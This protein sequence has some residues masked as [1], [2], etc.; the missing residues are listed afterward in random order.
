ML[1]GY[2]FK[3][4]NEK[5]NDLIIILLAALC[6]FN[7]YLSLFILL[8]G[9]KRLEKLAVIGFIFSLFLFHI[10]LYFIA[11]IEDKIP[12]IF[13]STSFYFFIIIIF[14]CLYYIKLFKIS[15]SK[16]RDE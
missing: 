12:M 11:H 8:F 3:K 2:L 5:F 4:V 9:P 15:N 16:V 13:L 1:S 6:F 10:L 7:Y 14:A